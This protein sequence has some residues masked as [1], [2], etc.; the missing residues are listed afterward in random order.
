VFVRCNKSTLPREINL[1]PL[2]TFPS[3]RAPQEKPPLDETFTPDILRL[4]NRLL[5]NHALLTIS[6]VLAGDHT[7]IE[8]ELT[9]LY[10]KSY[11]R[12]TLGLSP[13]QLNKIENFLLKT[14]KHQKLITDF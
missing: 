11:N 1:A 13:R 6:A 9:E 12:H 14:S 10:S 4:R 5:R 3:A 7:K 2:E 8:H